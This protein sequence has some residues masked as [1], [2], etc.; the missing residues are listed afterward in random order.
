[1]IF[2]I[3][4]CVWKSR[5]LISMQDLKND[6]KL[7]SQVHILYIYALANS[8]SLKFKKIILDWDTEH[9]RGLQKALKVKEHIHIFMVLF[10]DSC[11]QR[12]RIIRMPTRLSDTQLGGWYY[13]AIF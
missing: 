13:L 8:G 2:I 9:F 1:M 4:R 7:D 6:H 10:C 3:N 5:F 11:G 12:Q